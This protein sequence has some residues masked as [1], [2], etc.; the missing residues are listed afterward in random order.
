MS[1]TSLSVRGFRS[2][3]D[4]EIDFDPSITILV[5]ENDAGKT[6]IMRCIDLALGATQPDPGDLT[7]GHDAMEVTLRF[8]GVELI[9]GWRRIDTQVEPSEVCLSL[10]SSYRQELVAELEAETFDVNDP[11]CATRVRDIALLVGT[12][13]RANSNMHNVKGRII[14]AL[15]SDTPTFTGS[16]DHLAEIVRLDGRQLDDASQF[17]DRLFMTELKRHIWAE[18][19]D[20][21]ATILEHVAR[22][23][24]EHAVTVSTQMN[25]GDALQHLRTFLPRLEA[26][27]VHTEP[28]H[29]DLQFATRLMLV[30][31]GREVDLSSKGDGTKRRV[32]MALLE[33]RRR[34]AHATQRRSAYVLDEP[35]THLHASAQ[36]DMFETLRG[37]AASGHQVI[38][39]THS[40]FLLNAVP[41]HQVRML[42]I[43]EGHTRVRGISDTAAHGMLSALG[44]E[45]T[46]LFFARHVVLVE[47]EAEEA[48]LNAFWESRLGA[49]PQ[50]SLIKIVSTK[51][52]NNIPG[53][54]A[55]LS[56][57]H[58]GERVFVLYDADAIEKI[59]PVIHKVGV[60]AD[61]VFV[62]G[63]QEFEDAF[64]SSTLAACWSAAITA[65]GGKLAPG[66]TADGIE[67]C[68]E[69]CMAE[70]RKFS[71]ALRALNAGGSLRVSKPALATSL[72]RH[73]PHAEIPP[74]LR[75]LCDRLLDTVRRTPIAS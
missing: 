36:V 51:G 37:F 43:H 50:A 17:F 2:L 63:T 54:A 55:A 11:D 58:E 42:A 12:Q 29:R 16:V 66:W 60:P 10:S 22:R 1:L 19:L 59:Q 4:V 21:G 67:A 70:G 61:N 52:V 5:G 33:L 56:Q 44:I 25:D 9:R 38:V 30:E 18:R 75:G 74:V 57:L 32:T 71:R 48:F 23:V 20:D 69:R 45:N 14:E 64:E 31:N 6:S 62:V 68:R 28:Q 47:G 53:C 26:V 72:G 34:L 41:A 3:A 27:R 7:H 73:I 13:V 65:H 15:T 24:D 46:H 39:T 35:D 40:P 8:D 49:R